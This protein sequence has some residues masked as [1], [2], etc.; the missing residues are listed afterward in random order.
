MIKNVLVEN[1]G[2]GRKHAPA[3]ST[4]QKYAGAL[5]LYLDTDMTINEV[6]ARTGVSAGGFRFYLRRWHGGGRSTVATS[7]SLR[8]A[9]KYAA[10]IDSLRCRPRP[11][12][13][14]AAD[15]GLNPDVFRC[16][17][18]AH[19]P[20]LASRH[21]R[22]RTVQGRLVSSASREKY[23]EALRLYSTTAESLRSIASRL[24]LVYNSVGGYIR[25]NHPE[26]VAL[27]ASRVA[28]NA[29]A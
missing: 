25:R 12:A 9:A 11:V 29:N 20:E 8:A 3:P 2:N 7:C 13:Q 26:A 4:V 17:L 24:G 10:A 6:V 16:Y 14:V 5:A 23:A 27:H 1:A 18:R 15:F 19:E 22:M 28:A 21:G